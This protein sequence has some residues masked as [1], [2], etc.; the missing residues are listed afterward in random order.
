MPTELNAFIEN[1]DAQAALYTQILALEESKL[2]ALTEEDLGLLDAITGQE[3]VLTEKA[4]TLEE[5]RMELLGALGY[6]CETISELVHMV[7]EEDAPVLEE[8]ARALL[9]VIMKVKKL[10]SSSLEMTKI[11]LEIVEKLLQRAESKTPPV[12]YQQDGTI[13]KTLAE[14]RVIV[15]KA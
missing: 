7:P 6:E 9:D 1:L 11:R 15:D 5:S 3:E 10:N 14:G 13:H 4:L 12:T 2:T 8:S